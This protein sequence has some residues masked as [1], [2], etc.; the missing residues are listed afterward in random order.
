MK[1]TKVHI[2]AIGYELAPV[3]VASAE[4][5]ERLAPLYEALHF[6]EGQLEA[7]TGIGER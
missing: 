3:V 4:L 2:D 5:E 6:P 7:L 1:Y